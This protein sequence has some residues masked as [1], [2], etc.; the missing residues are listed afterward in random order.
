[1]NKESIAPVINQDLTKSSQ[2]PPNIPVKYAGFWVR[3]VA[4][5]VDCLIAGILSSLIIVSI[6]FVSGVL[7][8][9]NNRELESV[10]T[11]LIR[12]I[13]L[14][15][16]WAY[17]S[18]MTYY[19]GA[20]LGKMLVGITVKSENL[21]RLSFGRVL[22]RETLGKLVS[23]IIL[24]IGYIMAAFTQ[25]KQAL[26]DI[27]AHS[28][29]VYKD[30]SK[31]H[32][33]GLIVGIII[34]TILPAFAI[35][36]VVSSVVLVSLS[37]ARSKAQDSRI[38]SGHENVVGQN[39][40]TTSSSSI[41]GAPYSYTL[42]SGWKVA[43]ENNESIE[44]YKNSNSGEYVLL[45]VE[46]ILPA[47]MEKITS[48]TQINAADLLREGLKSRNPNASI[49]DIAT[50]SIGGEIA[51]VSMIK[52]A[53]TST[54]TGSSNKSQTILS[55]RYDTIHKGQYYSIMF[56][57]PYDEYESASVDFQSIIKSF[58]FK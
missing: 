58:T 52:Y 56:L 16:V 54:D 4:F 36:G 11:V 15:L 2:T 45:I 43:P 29:V 40:I 22:L 41:S 7:A 39:Q 37:T 49:I 55:T 48:I 25:R 3:F 28:V 31:S 1:M 35:L 13:Y 19:K 57:S 44:A 34:A 32:R 27:F 51:M 46:E 9:L 23:A 24:D 17:F 50:S 10:V 42:P 26:H 21:E 18:L 8:P 33:A 38:I 14:L 6:A 47:S 53:N 30:P 12:L 20:T 5:T